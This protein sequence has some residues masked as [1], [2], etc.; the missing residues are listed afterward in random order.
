PR[1]PANPWPQ[2]LTTANFFAAVPSGP[3]QKRPTRSQIPT[4]RSRPTK[5]GDE[6]RTAAPTPFQH[7]GATPKT[8]G[9]AFEALLW[10][11]YKTGTL[12]GRGE[13]SPQS[14]H[15]GGGGTKDGFNQAG[16]QDPVAGC[17]SAH[18]GS[19]TVAAPAQP[20]GRGP[21]RRRP[22]P[23]HD[24][25]HGS[26]VDDHDDGARSGACPA[27]PRRSAAGPCRP[28]GLTAP[29]H[30]PAGPRYPDG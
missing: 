21:S 30:A 17:P 27:R 28:G 22:R 11:C 20:R 19:G 2:S 6:R 14:E 16:Q 15:T 8:A 13:A 29:G 26:A 24:D 18:R 10:R 25:H 7:P 3:Q 23:D 12:R 4:G 9:Q 1:V 5:S